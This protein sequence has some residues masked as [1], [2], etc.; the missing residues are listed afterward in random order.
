MS[1][2]SRAS[3]PRSADSSRWPNLAR[4]RRTF[5]HPDCFF[6]F[7]VLAASPNRSALALMLAA[8]LGAAGDPLS[9]NAALDEGREPDAD[10]RLIG[11]VRSIPPAST[12]PG[13]PLP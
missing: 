4:Y 13:P 12:F 8:E 2:Y 3:S 10:P 7:T 5:S 1:G 9:V 6:A 11:A